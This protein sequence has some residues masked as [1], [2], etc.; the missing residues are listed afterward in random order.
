M[1]K[2]GLKIEELG[3]PSKTI[4]KNHKVFL[5][6]PKQICVKLHS[7][8]WKSKL[9]DK[10]KNWKQFAGLWIQH[11]TGYDGGCIE[12]AALWVVPM[13]KSISNLKTLF[14][15]IGLAIV[16]LTSTFPEFYVMFYSARAC[17]YTEQTTRTS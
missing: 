9:V 17:I 11:N 5:R 1:D 10:K 3:F 8:R 14:E 13:L 4:G 6:K 15:V 2:V 16:K 12:S 7:Y